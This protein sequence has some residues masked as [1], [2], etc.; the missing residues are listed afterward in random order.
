MTLEI[1]GLTATATGDCRTILAG[2]CVEVTKGEVVALLGASGSGKSMT[3]RAVLAL[4]PAG[5]RFAGRVAIAGTDILS[6]PEHERRAMRGRD[7]A[8][9]F[10]EPATALNPVKTIGAQIEEPLKLHTTLSASDR[11]NRVNAL[12]NETRLAETGIK[13]DRYPH[14]LSGGQRQRVALAIAMA[15]N[16]KVVVAD[17]PTSALDSVAAQRILDL[18]AEL[19]RHHASALLLITHDRAVAARADRVAVMA[20]GRIAEDGPAARV[21]GAPRSEAARRL[22]PAVERVQR[23]RVGEPVLSA[24]GLTVRLGGHVVLSDV[25]L[26][27]GRGERLAI[28]G[29]SGAGKTTLARALLG[30]VP[31]SGTIRLNGVPASMGTIRREVQLVFQDPA[32]S[33][34]PRH[35]VGRIVAEPLFPS[36]LSP[37]HRR[38]RVVTALERVGLSADA[39][40]RRPHA[41]SGGQRQR[42]A[43]ARALV[44]RPAVLIADEAM[45]ALDAALRSEIALLFAKLAE[46]DGMGLMMI[47]H[48]L[49]FAEPFAHRAIVIDGGRL[50]ES[51]T[52]D[53]LVDRPRHPATQALVSAYR[54]T[55]GCSA[56]LAPL[57]PQANGA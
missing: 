29:R 48:D 3:G 31:A 5:I 9:V 40:V 11:S 21:L 6:T 2:I 47:T 57:H 28:F 27:V 44:T 37:D 14:T 34:N 15:L 24:S 38:E 8:M 49:A 41:F 56:G 19:V 35:T 52:M 54:A 23:A 55:R 46:E 50:V 22:L 10:Q 32:S 7:V 42:I 1:E 18:L 16:P 43:I 26:A 53:D 12:L 51:G 36:G 25:S 17:E 20:D 39:T 33:F 13:P 4:P 30:L 45:S